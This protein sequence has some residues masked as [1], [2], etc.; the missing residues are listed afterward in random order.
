VAKAERLPYDE[1]DKTEQD[2]HKR[3]ASFAGSNSLY[4]SND[5][6]YYGQF[7]NLPGCGSMW[8]PYFANAAWDPFSSGVWAY[9]P[10]A[11]YSWVSPYPWGWLPF[12]SGSWQMCGAAGWGWRPGGSWY[13]LQNAG[14]QNID[15]RR[16]P[17]KIPSHPVLPPKN[18][19]SGLVPVNLHQLQRSGMTDAETFQFRQ[20]S[21]GMGVPR[22]A[23]GGLHETS[24]FVEHH[25]MASEGVSMPQFSRHDGSAM[26]NGVGRGGH[27][28]PVPMSN[29]RVNSMAGNPGGGGMDRGG[30][31]GMSR[32]GGQMGSPNAGASRSPSMNSPSTGFGANFPGGHSAPSA[33]AAA[34]AAAGGGGVRH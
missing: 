13:G 15:L 30:S 6:S 20:N 33:P 14:L 17:G 11:G 31:V 4:G 28:M 29:M 5:L 25:G 7:A 22:H 27:E 16:L 24:R 12:H 8:R 34:P 2:Y 21:A 18:G 23:F 26:A 19:Q 9:Y 32:G 3:A 10:T 1:W